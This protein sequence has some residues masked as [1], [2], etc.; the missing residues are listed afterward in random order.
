M[1]TIYGKKNCGLCRK[2]IMVL[3]LLGKPYS[4]KELEVD[5]TEQYFMDKFPGKNQFPQVMLDEK[6]LGDCNETIAYLKEHRI[7]S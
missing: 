2:I 5:F 6:H 4:Y 1:Y 3:E 7:L